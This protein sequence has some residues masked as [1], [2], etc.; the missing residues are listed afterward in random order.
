MSIYPLSSIPGVASIYQE[1][2]PMETTQIN[3]V[4]ALFHRER[5]ELRSLMNQDPAFAPFRDLPDSMLTFLCGEKQRLALAPNTRTI[6]NETGEIIGGY[7]CHFSSPDDRYHPKV[8]SPF[9][10][11]GYWIPQSKGELFTAVELEG[12]LV[13]SRGGE[14]E[15]LF[16]VHPSSQELY[17][18]LRRKYAQEK[19]DIPAL[20]LSSFRSLVIAVPQVIGSPVYTMVKVSLDQMI[21]G[22]E[23]RLHRKECACSVATNA[24]LQNRK[25]TLRFFAEEWSFLPDREL[26]NPNHSVAQARGAGMIHRPLPNWLMR[27]DCELYPIPLFAL[28]GRKNWPLLKTMIQQSTMTP[29]EWIKDKLLMPFAEILVDH[30]FFQ[31]T[32]LELHG[33][34]LLL[35]ITT[36]ESCEAEIGFAYRDLRGA[37]TVFSDEELALLPKGLQNREFFYSE[38]FVRDAA[39]VVE[40]IARRIC[41]GFTKQL[42]KAED[43]DE[44][45]PSFAEWKGQM[46]RLGYEGNWTIPGLDNDDHVQEHTVQTFFRYGYFSKI[47]GHCLLE[48]MN[49]EAIF[50]DLNDHDPTLNFQYFKEKLGDP[51]EPCLSNDWF[52]DLITISLSYLI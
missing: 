9:I 37:N 24:L 22:V 1:P 27:P 47:F 40:S 29:T 13:R 42:F 48:V 21:G 46:I 39:W 51:L 52:K 32:S 34:N 31:K 10:L 41:F 33:Q 38:S 18:P 19:V 6:H 16:L 8:M 11:E 44:M 5:S 30:L 28:F 12:P 7:S 20:S 35:T 25:E 43:I 3:E 15:I 50:L 17:E 14:I 23:R 2:V 45:D 36:D 4:E 26:L 49:R